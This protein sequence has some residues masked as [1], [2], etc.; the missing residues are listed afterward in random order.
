MN[1]Q[2]ARTEEAVRF[3]TGVTLAFAAYHVIDDDFPGS[4]PK[5]VGL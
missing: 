4:K 2:N 3:N 5:S 1:S